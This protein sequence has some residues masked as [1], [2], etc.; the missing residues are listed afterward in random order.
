M[1]ARGGAALLVLVA[2]MGSIGP[3][4]AYADIATSSSYQVYGGSF[5]AVTS[6]ALEST[7]GTPAIGSAA[8]T[9]SGPIAPGL[10]VGSS[11]LAVFGGFWGV[12]RQGFGFCG[13]ANPVPPEECD[14]GGTVD[15]DGCSATCQLEDETSFFGIAVGGQT[16]AIDVDGQT[17]SIPTTAGQTAADIAGALAAAINADPTLQ[18]LGIA[19]LA[20]DNRLVTN[21]TLSNLTIGDTGISTTMVVPLLTPISILLLGLMITGLGVSARLRSTSGAKATKGA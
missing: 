7:A 21:G 11:G 14:D 8:G 18:S 15:G 6:A 9:L 1:M 4:V 20:I 12:A 16:I 10:A 2:W 5:S 3:T 13:D 19:A 17:I